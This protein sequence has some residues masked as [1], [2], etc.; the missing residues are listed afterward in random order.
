MQYVPNSRSIYKLEFSS[1][2]DDG[3]SSNC[4]VFRTNSSLPQK[5]KMDDTVHTEV[6]NKYLEYEN[7]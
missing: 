3:D 7:I 2:E 4:L 5:Q 6:I 1:F